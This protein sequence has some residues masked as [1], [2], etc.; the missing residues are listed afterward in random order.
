LRD[1]AYSPGVAD[2]DSDG[3]DGENEED[4]VW[5]ITDVIDLHT[6]APRDVASLVP[7]YIDE[8]VARGFRQVRII[9]GKGTGTLRRIVQAAL[10]RHDAVES[11]ALADE[12]RGGWG[13]TV[14]QLKG[15]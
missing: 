1:V 10:D 15:G 14:A 13:A 3:A 7:D 9:H 6:F 11:Y 4:V 12:S 5:E 8:C 2:D